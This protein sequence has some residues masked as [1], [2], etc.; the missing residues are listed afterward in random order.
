MTLTEIYLKAAQVIRANGHYKGAYYESAPEAGVGIQFA[1]TEC[2][3]CIA[4][5]VSMAMTGWP[6]PGGWDDD[7]R[8]EFDAAARR[9]AELVGAE[10]DPLL[11]PVGRLAG[12][13]DADDRTAADVIAALE[14]AAK[15]VA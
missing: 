9:L 1:P 7:G 12:W 11:E 4:G 10:D 6:I 13:N 3:M 14:Q 15:A 5:A 2:S 8:A